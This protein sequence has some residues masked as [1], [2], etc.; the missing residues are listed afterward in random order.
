MRNS[1][2]LFGGALVLAGCTG[3]STVTNF[4]YNSAY[5]PAHVTLAAAN[6]PAQAVIRG[7]P[8]AN[9]VDNQGVIAAM[10]GQ[11]WGPK[12][13]FTPTARSDDIYGYKMVLAFNGIGP[14]NDL[15]R[16][17]SAPPKPSGTDRID[18]SIAFCVGEVLLTDASGHITGVAG[19]GDPK[20]K[21]LVSDLMLTVTPPYD[22]NRRGDDGV[23]LG[24]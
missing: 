14:N 15:C 17:P 24:C 13:F 19:P 4:Y 7:N 3:V 8:F 5:T 20:F 11:N 18:A 12:I 10:Q 22:P 2:L 1:V 6:N 21:R 9:D 16:A 23:G